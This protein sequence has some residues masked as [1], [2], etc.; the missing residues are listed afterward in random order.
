M[1]FQN[2]QSQKLFNWFK[3]I[4]VI[5]LLLVNNVASYSQQKL[6]GL[7]W[8]FNQ[9]DTILFA[10]TD[11]DDAGWPVINDVAS[12]SNFSWLRVKVKLP[13][14]VN[15][16]T[17]VFLVALGKVADADEV[18]WNGIKV[19]HTG[20]W[21]HDAESSKDISR[22]YIIN[23]SE[24]SKSFFK[25]DNM[26][27]IRI[28]RRNGMNNNFQNNDY[29]VYFRTA[30][31]KFGYSFA[32]PHRLTTCLP[33]SSDKTLIDVVYDKIKMTWTYDNLNYY[34]YDSYK[35]P[36]DYISLSIQPF[37][38]KKAFDYP[39]YERLDGYLPVLNSTFRKDKISMNLQVAGGRSAAITKIVLRNNAAE[40]QTVSLRTERLGGQWAGYNVA[41]IDTALT[42]NMLI[43][44]YGARAD[45]VIAFGLGADS[46]PKDTLSTTFFMQ[47]QLQPG[48]EKTG[49]LIRPYNSFY[50]D[51]LTLKQHDWNKEFNESKQTWVDLIASAHSITIPDQ[52]T[53]NAYYASLADCYVM[54]EPVGNN[55]LAI[56][57]GTEMYRTGPNPIESALVSIALDEAGLSKDAEEGYRVNLDLQE[58][59]GNW[60]EPAG[61]THS[62]WAASGFKAWA[63]IEHF[64]LTKD[65]AFLIKRYP[66]LLNN[67][68]WQ[69]KQRMK[70]RVK[71]TGIDSL[72]F[73]LMP[74]GMGDCGLY[75]G[76]DLYGVFIPHNIWAVFADSISLLAAK[77][78]K[79]ETDIKELGKIYQTGKK[80]L[81][82]AMR[83]GAIPEKDGSRWIP[84]VA[85]KKEGS[86]WGA[87]N[88]LYPT[89]ILDGNDSLVSGTFK[90]LENYISPGGIPINTGWLKGGMWVA[91]AVDNFGQAYLAN[92]NGSTAA[93]YLK[94]TLNHGS[95]LY[96]WCEERGQESYTTVTT[97]DIQHLWT[98]VAI[99][100]YLRDAL[101]REE[102]NN[103]FL[104]QGV[105][106]MWVLS[107]MEIGTSKS[108]THV[109][110]VSYK[111]L[112]DRK[113]SVLKGE[114]LLPETKNN[115]N[116][117][118]YSGLPPNYKIV[119]VNKTSGATITNKGRSLKWVNAKGVIKF[120][121]KI[122][123][124]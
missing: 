54:Q 8:K 76:T 11:Y 59:D 12:N 1:N 56:T 45:Q 101:V 41:W 106:S 27:A 63:L 81:I 35:P 5:L 121:A 89:H 18:Y 117:I 6:Q 99:A 50:A 111:Y 36:K 96:T 46:Y 55:Y 29:A 88:A 83:R 47:W 120:E 82:T 87:L 97:G 124:N 107:G 14:S 32:P 64:L 100:R 53:Q 39:K 74:R 112:Y 85:G 31:E 3:G 114:I 103:L 123:Y 43:A 90:Y 33:K 69:E 91:I 61:W 77:I 95:P 66:Q 79:R 70:T 25:K 20:S 42:A 68:K 26:L 115:F 122:K 7:T 57:P 48:E 17:G 73:G 24:K 23:Y 9:A 108:P 118:L 51:S 16:A 94:A 119:K 44:A 52:F 80:D 2:M 58:K 110:I 15:S 71:A 113:N 21:L 102:S 92:D 37:L 116:T 22:N 67:S 60:T 62:M 104:A 4:A 78:L 49:W 93:T 109:G 10:Q 84:A 40:T 19:H 98:P 75:N 105:D 65:T 28:L 34:P 72:N 86:R 13:D 38:N 30:E